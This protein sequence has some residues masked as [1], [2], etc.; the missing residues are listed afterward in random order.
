MNC[1]V[2]Q[3]R[4]QDF[5][6]GGTNLVGVRRLPTQLRFENFV[7]QRKRIWT[8]RGRAPAAPPDPPMYTTPFIKMS[9][10][11]CVGMIQLFVNVLFDFWPSDFLG[12]SRAGSNPI[13]GEIF[14]V[15]I[16]IFHKDLKTITFSFTAIEEIESRSVVILAF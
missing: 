15:K 16:V 8:L 14:L 13:H 9:D 4:I 5:P 6:K 11:N 10:S 12:T 7:C 1:N 3:W 2:Y